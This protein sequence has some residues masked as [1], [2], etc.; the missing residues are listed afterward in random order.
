M[1][2]REANGIQPSEDIG[3]YAR[4]EI[5][6]SRRK[7]GPST[8]DMTQGG[9]C[10]H[11]NAVRLPHVARPLPS[12]D[13]AWWMGVYCRRSSLSRLSGGDWSIVLLEE[14][15]E[16]EAARLSSSSVL[17]TIRDLAARCTLHAALH[18][19]FPSSRKSSCD[20]QAPALLRSQQQGGRPIR[21]HRRRVRL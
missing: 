2:E 3:G 10:W 8:L 11:R 19:G 9:T 5:T 15:A 12:R 17:L 21:C 16:L 14:A 1:S 7:N 4:V 6:T 13:V 18:L 20:L